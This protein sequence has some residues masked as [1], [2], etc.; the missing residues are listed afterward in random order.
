V[1]S[2]RLLEGVEKQQRTPP[3]S[4]GEFKFS[5]NEEMLTQIQRRGAGSTAHAAS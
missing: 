5:T 4:I 2:L 3:D 1:E